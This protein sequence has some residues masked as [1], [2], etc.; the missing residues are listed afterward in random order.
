MTELWTPPCVYDSPTPRLDSVS[1]FDTQS[2]AEARSASA[3]LPRRKKSDTRPVRPTAHAHTLA[4]AKSVHGQ[5]KPAHCATAAAP[6]ELWASCRALTATKWYRT[7]VSIASMPSEFARLYSVVFEIM[8]GLC[9]P[10]STERCKQE[11]GQRAYVEK[12]PS[13]E[14]SGTDLTSWS[15]PRVL[16]VRIWRA[17]LGMSWA[18][19]GVALAAAPDALV[20]FVF[21]FL[22]FSPL[23]PFACVTP[24]V[25]DNEAHGYLP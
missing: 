12:G 8:F 17:W 3:H 10:S 1:V 19:A 6:P 20:V 2:A 11:A 18:L 5:S 25:C 21:L 4:R 13:K 9:A 23:T 24:K 14:G 22:P 15:P 7:T 16:F